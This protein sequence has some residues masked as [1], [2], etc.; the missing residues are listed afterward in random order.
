MR[1]GNICGVLVMTVAVSMCGMAGE[2]LKSELDARRN[3]FNAR[4]PED[5]KKIYEDGVSAVADSGI[6]DSAKQVG[7]E[8]PNFA[9]GNAT[10][11]VVKL[12]DYLE[13]GSV[14]L[15]WYRGGWCPYCNL[16][17]HSM[18]QHLPE[19]RVLGA[20]LL[21]LTP[22]LPDRSL[23]TA[24]KNE[25]E[26]EVLSD[27][28]SKVAHEYGLVFKLTDDVA[29]IYEEKFGLSEYNG[30]DSNELPLAA[31]YVINPEGKIIYAFVDADYR[32][33]AEPSDIIAAL[34]R[35]KK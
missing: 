28:D 32:N 26:F 30:N 24:E 31:T 14:I 19:F 15:T 22:E 27:I 8:A 2:S 9:L 5:V 20:N 17:M 13:K 7:D 1:Y 11:T 10:G 29:A 12:S 4:A 6:L 18:Q 21:A 33:R 3:A 25:L 16:T 34:K 23:S 35:S